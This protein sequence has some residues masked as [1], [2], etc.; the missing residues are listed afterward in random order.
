MADL[1]KLGTAHS[2]APGAD[3]GPLAGLYEMVGDV[4]MFSIFALVSA[5]LLIVLLRVAFGLAFGWRK[6]RGAQDTLEDVGAADSRMLRKLREAERDREEE[7]RR[8]AS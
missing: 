6:R 3:P 8:Y 4:V 2:Y 5:I 1:P 7:R